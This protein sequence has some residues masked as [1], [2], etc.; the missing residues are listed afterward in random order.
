MAMSINDDV[1]AKDVK[2]FR[3]TKT[4]VVVD[5][6]SAPQTSSDLNQHRA[7]QWPKI[8]TSTIT[9]EIIP[10]MVREYFTLNRCQI[11]IPLF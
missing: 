2:L 8:P 5:T 7:A 9:R 6:M 4:N 1:S 11:S 10:V 3:P